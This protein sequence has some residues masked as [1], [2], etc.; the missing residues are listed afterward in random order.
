[1][2]T[3]RSLAIRLRRFHEHDEDLRRQLAW[4]IANGKTPVD[5]TF[6]FLTIRDSLPTSKLGRGQGPLRL[7]VSGA[8]AFVDRVQMGDSAPEQE[9]AAR[10]Q[11]HAAEL[12][13]HVH[14]GGH[15]IIHGGTKLGFVLDGVSAADTAAL[16]DRF[17]YRFH[18]PDPVRGVGWAL[19][20]FYRPPDSDLPATDYWFSPSSDPYVVAAF[21]RFW[22]AAYQECT[23]ESGAKRFRSADGVS[24]WIPCPPPEF[25]LAIRYGSLPP[26]P[27][28]PFGFDLL[29]RE[30]DE[31]GRLGS[32]WGGRRGGIGDEWIDVSPPNGDPGAPRGRGTRGLVLVHIIGRQ[33]TGL[34]E[35][36][37]VYAFD[38]PCLGIVVPEGGPCIEVVIAEGGA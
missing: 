5:A 28:S 9:L 13:R 33:A 15:V 16:L 35:R 21:L 6:R 7:D 3:H 1:V 37:S 30:V 27:S 4:N 31:E 19:K 12:S 25:N 29:D 10:N 38:R 36:G 34:N 26:E 32:R 11:T 14:A 22:A 20:G 8:R 24:D 2:F 17:S 18:N 23:R